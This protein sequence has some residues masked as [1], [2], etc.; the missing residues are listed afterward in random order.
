LA[1]DPILATDEFKSRVS[2]PI[3]GSG[4]SC[5]VQMTVVVIVIAAFI[6]LCNTSRSRDHRKT[7]MDNLRRIHWA[8]DSFYTEYGSR[9]V[10]TESNLV[11]YLGDI[12]NC[13]CPLLEGTNR[14]FAASYEINPVGVLPECKVAS[15]RQDHVLRRPE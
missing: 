10:M 13:F 5:M 4:I 7:C 6:P 15:V 8:K 9:A 14:T 2:W 1:D 11:P 3:R 12:E